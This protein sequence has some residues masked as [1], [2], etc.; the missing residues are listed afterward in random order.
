MTK[1]CRKVQRLQKLHAIFFQQL[2][3]Y[4]E[5]KFHLIY[6]YSSYNLH[7]K[8]VM[9]NKLITKRRSHKRQNNNVNFLSLLH[10]LPEGMRGC[11]T[12]VAFTLHESLLKIS[13]DYRIP[14]GWLVCIALRA[15]P[16]IMYSTYIVHSVECQ[17]I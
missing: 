17:F 6:I 4:A 13:I 7:C 10:K 3:T 12:G 11:D 9:Q 16:A 14:T 5:V 15:S 2:H 1:V 8:T